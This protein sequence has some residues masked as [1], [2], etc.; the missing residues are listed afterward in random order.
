MSRVLR[1]LG[2]TLATTLAV[3]L[4]L[5]PIYWM[6][7]TATVPSHIVLSRNPPLLPHWADMSMDAFAGIMARR[8]VLTWLANSMIVATSSVAV[9]LV[10]ATLAGYSLSR[11]R[12]AAQELS[13]M[14]LLVTKMLPGSLIVIP[15]YIMAAN[16]NLVDN[17]L[18]LVIANTSV[19]VPFATWM[20]KGFFD[21][22]P[23]DLDAAA[24]I[25]GCSRLQALR[26]V[27]LPAARPGIAASAIYLFIVAW[28]DFVFARTLVTDP[29]L[30]TV[31]TG[32]ASFVG[33]HNVDWPGL[34][35]AGTLSM[36]PVFAL[37]LLLEPWLVSGMSAGAVK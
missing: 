28:A 20:M 19:G 11:F 36:L 4:I 33:E 8:P 35:A 37:F 32:L 27:V 12:S 13:G 14:A 18:A 15:F 16:A 3:A 23:A 34:M 17:R 22:I 9:S 6:G 5:F 25:D 1:P 7:V 24:R 30:W 29:R 31:T 10:I 2:L 21:G 26:Y